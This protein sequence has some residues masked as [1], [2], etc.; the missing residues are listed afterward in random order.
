LGP[1]VENQNHK[2]SPTQ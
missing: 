1:T 2:K